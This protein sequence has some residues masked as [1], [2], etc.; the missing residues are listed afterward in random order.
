MSDE[1]TGVTPAEETAPVTQ[2][3]ENTEVESASEVTEATP[4][5]EEPS[6]DYKAEAEV[7]QQKL[8][9]AEYTLRKKNVDSK[10][11]SEEEVESLDQR[12]EAK[13]AEL[14]EKFD[15]RV[16]AIRM[17]DAR[18]TFDEELSAAS[19]NPD[20]RDLIR[21]HYE[22]SIVK[23]GFSRAAVREDLDKAKALAN[24]KKILKQNHE[25]AEAVKAKGAMGNTAQGSNKDRPTAQEDLESKFTAH[26]WAYMKKRGWSD[27]KIRK[28]AALQKE[29]KQGG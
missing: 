22:N 1:D 29:R 9:K 17:D 5:E 16:K 6:I 4:V 26:D 12:L 27:E 21:L 13:A 24:A 8:D 25:L 23:S 3:E 20:E 14:E 18:D 19:E 15:E 2:A 10:K 11:A 28:A 7:L